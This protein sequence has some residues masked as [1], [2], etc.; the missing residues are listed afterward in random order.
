[1]HDSLRTETILSLERTPTK[2]AC[3]EDALQKLREQDQLANKE[4]SKRGNGI[5]KETEYQIQQ[6]RIGLI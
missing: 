6:N 3:S 2:P 5:S 1:M 4:M